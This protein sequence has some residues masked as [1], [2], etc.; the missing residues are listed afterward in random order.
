MSL[1]GQRGGRRLLCE[2]PT[3]L[4]RPEVELCRPLVAPSEKPFNLGIR[5]VSAK[6]LLIEDLSFSSKN[7][8]TVASIIK[9]PISHD[10]FLSTLDRALRE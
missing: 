5:Q 7:H 3:I 9:A 2:L 4:P 1:R 6:N 8:L 10:R